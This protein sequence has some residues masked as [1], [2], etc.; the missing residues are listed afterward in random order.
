MTGADVSR[1]L[2][3][4][5]SPE[6]SGGRP[7][8]L[9]PLGSTEQHGPHLPLDTDTRIAVGI[10]RAAARTSA[11]PLVVAPAVAYGASGEHEGFAGTLSVGQEVLER[12]VVELARSARG[13]HRLVVLVNGHGGNAEA[14]ARAMKTLDHEDPDVLAWA[15]SRPAG[16]GDGDSHAGRVETS[17]LLAL[18]PDAV[19]LD[20]AVPGVIRPLGELMDDLRAGGLAAVTPNGVLGDPTGA[21]AEEGRRLI[22]GW[23]A[24]LNAAVAA[25]LDGR[26]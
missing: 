11:A 18:V 3:D 1:D 25:R 23:A 2:G 15:P 26:E 17:A 7:A 16:V 10:A 5:T 19:H 13:R 8:L 4:W 6:V 24:D 12:I 21:S 20:R 14:L 22:A 9:I